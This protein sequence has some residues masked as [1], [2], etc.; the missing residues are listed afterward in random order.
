[1]DARQ[2]RRLR[3]RKAEEWFNTEYRALKMYARLHGVHDLL[4]FDS[5]EAKPFIE[6]YNKRRLLEA[7]IDY[8]VKNP[9][10]PSVKQMQSDWMHPIY[11]GWL[12]EQLRDKTD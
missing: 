1:M 11:W 10:S 7:W 5:F 6:R 9:T 12:R 8:K 3:R 2:R 4:P